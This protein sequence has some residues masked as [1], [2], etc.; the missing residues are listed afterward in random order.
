MAALSSKLSPAQQLAADA[1]LARA[2]SEASLRL[3]TS[4]RGA[5]VASTSLVTAT[6]RRQMENPMN[7]VLQEELSL[8]DEDDWV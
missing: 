6:G 7:V 8:S 1:Q 3:Q 2:Q 4:L 5:G